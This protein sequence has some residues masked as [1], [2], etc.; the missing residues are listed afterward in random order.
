MQPPASTHGETESEEVA[1]VW[2][3]GSSGGLKLGKKKPVKQQEH[4]E[5]CVDIQGG[6]PGPWWVKGGLA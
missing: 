5:V 1:L 3:K 2:Q 6:P 4:T